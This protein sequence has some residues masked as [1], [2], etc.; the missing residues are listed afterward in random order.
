M[1]IS[2]YQAINSLLP[3]PK[4]AVKQDGSSYTIQ[5]WTDT[6]TQP[7]N[8][9][10]DAEITRLTNLEPM[11]KLRERRNRLLTET[12]WMAGSDVTMTTAWKD[13]R[14]ALR[15]LPASSDPKLNSE[16]YLDLS[17]VTW[18]VKP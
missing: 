13:Y 9:A 18:P 11:T 16:G 4:C 2:A 3:N 15:D 14:K 5:A 7:T 6:R 10:I 17:S 8:S 12:D 1:T